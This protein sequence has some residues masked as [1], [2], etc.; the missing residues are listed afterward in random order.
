MK[1][2]W[3]KGDKVWWFC[4]QWN[5][6]IQMKVFQVLQLKFGDRPTIVRYRLESP[7]GR[8]C[9]AEVDERDIDNLPHDLVEEDVL[10]DKKEQAYEHLFAYMR[11]EADR[12]HKQADD[13]L[14]NIDRI[15]VRNGLNK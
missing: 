5:G 6:V 7:D 15:K 12:L 8:D 11:M 2:K 4:K 13:M 1:T 3:H 14:A 9:K 10:F